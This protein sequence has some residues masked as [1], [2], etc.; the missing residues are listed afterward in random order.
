MNGTTNNTGTGTWTV[1]ATAGNAVL[2]VGSGIAMTLNNILVGNVSGAGAAMNIGSS[3]TVTTT[4]ATAVNTIFSTSIAANSYGYIN[5]AGA[6]TTSR[7]EIGAAAATTTVGGIGVGV[8][9]GG[10]INA[11]D[12][13]IIGLQGSPVG[14]SFTLTGG[15][16]NTTNQN[17][18]V[19]YNT[20]AGTNVFNIQGGNVNV[21]GSKAFKLND[22]GNAGTAVN[23][24]NLNGGVLKTVSVTAGTGSTN[25]FNFNGG[26][27]QAATTAPAFMQGLTSAYVHAGGAVIDTN[28]FAATIA[29]SLLTPTGGGVSGTVS[30]D[31]NVGSGY[32]GAPLVT[33]AGTARRC[34]RYC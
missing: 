8:M 20:A 1:G 6:I 7:F 28:G 17:L 27:L 9:S 15:T 29:Q 32:I 21:G 24:A 25:I 19:S 2:N 11:T 33:I 14:N 16:I 3:S 12:Y 31:G 26:T 30:L 34:Y 10:T 13:F 5:N 18:N 22:V 4:L 23:V